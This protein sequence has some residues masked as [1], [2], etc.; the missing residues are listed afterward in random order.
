MTDSA[1]ASLFD[2][3]DPG[4]SG[5][6]AKSRPVKWSYSRRGN[7]ETC[8]LKYY[9]QYYGSSAR[10]APN[11]PLKGQLKFLK[12]LKSIPL[13]MGEIVHFVIDRHFKRLRENPGNTN[14]GIDSWA[15]D[16]FRKDLEASLEY[17]RTGQPASQYAVLLSD[18]VLGDDA[19]M[20]KWNSANESLGNAVRNFLGSRQ[21]ET[22]R[23]GGVHSDA[24]LEEKLSVKLGESAAS[25]KIDLAF[26]GEDGISIVDWKTGTSTSADD[27]LQ[28]LSYALLVSNK[29]G[30]EPERIRIFK[31]YLELDSVIEN[32]ASV[33]EI[34]RA[35]VRIIQDIGRMEAMDRYGSTGISG[36]FTPSE[37]VKIC[38]MCP[39]RT[40]CPEFQR[41]N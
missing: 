13:R 39:F 41:S 4:Y 11:E 14:T 1:Q 30:I 35:K 5:A 10:L 25:G 8:L 33:Q 2:L 34:L 22:F 29:L 23:Y 12:G 38:M 16:M 36:A 37:H 28:L 18:F 19:A 21:F 6:A 15:R 9:Y 7:F 3:V 20:E 17:K 40:V 32:R 31:A 27:S 26:P 24:I